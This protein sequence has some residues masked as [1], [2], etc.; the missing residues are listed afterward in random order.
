MRLLAELPPTREAEGR[1]T[2]WDDAGQCLLGPARCRG[3]ADDAEERRHGTADDDPV[4]AYG[5]HP[6]GTYLVVSMV[7]DPEPPRSYGPYFFSLLPKE[8]EALA[9]WEAGRRGLGIHGG[10]PGPGSS[11][12]ATYGCLRVENATCDELATLL[13]PDFAARRP[14][15]YDC[16]PLVERSDA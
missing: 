15:F 1:L 7:R 14:V 8:G 4:H 10:D 5:D 11:L 9:A 16:R 13:A 6:Y 12:R 3:E 2:V